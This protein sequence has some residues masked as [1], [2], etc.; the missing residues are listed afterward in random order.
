MMSISTKNHIKIM[1]M[2]QYCDNDLQSTKGQIN[3]IMKAVSN[4]KKMKFVEWPMKKLIIQYK[5]VDCL[6]VE[7]VNDEHCWN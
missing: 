4:L 1:E 3:Y 2:H 7:I 5:W 6:W